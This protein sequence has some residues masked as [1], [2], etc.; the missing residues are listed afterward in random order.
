MPAAPGW[1]EPGIYQGKHLFVMALRK[2]VQGL[3]WPGR[4]WAVPLV[5]T[6]CAKTEQFGADPHRVRL[7]QAV[8]GRLGGRDQPVGWVKLHETQGFG[9]GCSQPVLIGV[10]WQDDEHALFMGGLV[11][12]FHQRVG[13]GVEGQQGVAVDHCPLG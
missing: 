7:K 3:A 1:L 11:K 12:L 8:R 6:G 2:E 13:V 10:R 9:G 5:A 4:G